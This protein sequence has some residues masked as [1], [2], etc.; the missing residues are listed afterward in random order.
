M[1]PKQP[2]LAVL[3]AANAVLLAFLLLNAPSA[4]RP[5][6]ARE[7][8]SRPAAATS[9][10]AKGAL[11]PADAAT[12]IRSRELLATDDM[13][14]LVARL[15]AAGFSQADIW[16][17]VYNRL[18]Q[19][20]GARNAAIAAQMEPVPYW[21]GQYH[22]NPKIWA[23]IREQMIQT[24]QLA[25]ES[26]ENPYWRLRQQQEY[27]YLPTEKV[28][29]LKQIMGDYADMRSTLYYEQ[30][31]FTLPEDKAKLALLEKEQQADLANLLTP[32][33]LEAY[34]LHT[35]NVSGQLRNELASF[36]PSEAE[37]IALYRLKVKAD[38]TLNQRPLA[39]EWQQQLEAALGPERAADYLRTTNY[40]YMET[41]RLVARF[42]LP[43]TLVPQVNNLQRDLQQRI[44]AV[45][46]D[47]SLSPSARQNV[48]GV[49][50]AE[51]DAR[52]P[53]LLGERGYAAYRSTVG[54]WLDNL[55]PQP[56]KE[57]GK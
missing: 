29:R 55:N 22:E 5:D 16:S 46:K 43:S 19:I 3:L 52:F 33:E 57:G 2:L 47:S 39:P 40:D 28:E 44:Q 36:Q 31:G 30:R 49:L 53:A 48:L 50:A 13:P 12:L 21:R 18:G 11:S 8:P 56:A 41:D 14:T 6:S 42:D 51:A 9:I 7:N 37:F 27:N 17:I 54:H 32:E 35:G 23:N 34:Q 4:P 25:G 38:Q 10:P 15:R 24:K 45:N 1:K 20:Y 26:P